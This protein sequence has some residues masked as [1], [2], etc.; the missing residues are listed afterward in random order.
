MRKWKVIIANA[1]VAENINETV[2]TQNVIFTLLRRSSKRN[3]TKSL[4]KNIRTQIMSKT[5]HSFIVIK[6]LNSNTKWH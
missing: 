4:A 5:D 3:W 6:R 1:E 2:K